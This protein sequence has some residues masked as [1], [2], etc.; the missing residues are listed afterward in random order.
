MF[1]SAFLLHANNADIK[2]FIETNSDVK[3][4]V[5]NNSKYPW[6]FDGTKLVPPSESSSSDLIITYE[7]DS[8]TTIKIEGD[9]YSV[10]IDDITV[11]IDITFTEK[12]DK[13]SYSTDM[14]LQDRLTTIKQQDPEKYNYV[15]ANILYAKQI[16]KDAGVYKPNRGEMPQVGLGGVGGYILEALTRA[17]VEN[18]DLIDNDTINIRFRNKTISTY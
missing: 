5:L 7:S 2:A 9:D 11:D 15:V 6:T 1:L 17:G 10:T 8:M 13:I 18:L 16:L 4:E 12:T 14:A 3:V